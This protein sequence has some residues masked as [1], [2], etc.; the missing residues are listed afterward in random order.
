M[1]RMPRTEQIRKTL[2]T[3]SKA[4]MK[5]TLSCSRIRKIARQM[6]RGHWA[7]AFLAVFICAV[8]INGPAY[9]AYYLS[10]SKTVNSIISVY[11]LLINGPLILAL[12]GYFL[13]VF[14]GSAEYSMGSFTS[15]ANY[16]ING[17][18]LYVVEMLL[19]VLRCMF[20]VFALSLAVYGYSPVFYVLGALLLIPGILAAIQYSQAF[21]VLAEQPDT[22]PMECIR[23]SRQLMNGNKGKFVLLQLSFVPWMV[24]A[25]LPSGIVRSQLVGTISAN[26]LYDMEGLISRLDA[27][28]MNPAVVL[29]SL[30]TLLAEAY[31]LASNAC[32]YDLACG[33]LVVEHGDVTYEGYIADS[34]DRYEITGFESKYK[35]QQEDRDETQGLH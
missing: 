15:R 20:S 1:R 12:T 29:L 9:I 27:A 14:R 7:G 5:V 3:N 33:S 32:F 6:F 35:D 21:F 22:R 16:I 10:A 18:M 23:R 8:L 4:Q 31:M 24:L 25:A 17:L 19:I 13:D 26:S 11:S 34:V 30:L 28:S 2:K